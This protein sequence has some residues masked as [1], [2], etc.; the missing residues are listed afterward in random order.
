MVCDVLYFVVFDRFFKV[1]VFFFVI[2]VGNRVVKGSN[3][4][5][6]FFRFVV[7]LRREVVLRFEV[8]FRFIFFIILIYVLFVRDELRVIVGG[9]LF[10]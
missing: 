4:F 10:L 2:R 1:R 7:V 9:F 8:V 5:F 3:F 6:C